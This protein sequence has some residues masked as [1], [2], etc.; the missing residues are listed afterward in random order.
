MWWTNIVGG[1]VLLIVATY[2]IQ[3]LVPSSR[4]KG[5]R[6][7][8]YLR[9]DI[10]P[11]I[12]FFG[13]LLLGLSFAEA[14]R[15]GVIASWGWGI[16]LGLL[17]SAGVWWLLSFRQNRAARRQVS[18]WQILRRYGTPVIAAAI[19]MYLAV[20]VFGAALEVS[21]AAALGLLV[22]AA[23][24]ALFVGSKPISEENHGK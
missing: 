22:I 4:S 24:V 20:R 3:W 13:V 18:V 14:A 19:G 10:A 21:V 2:V 17:I 5:T 16:L 11:I 1:L 23:A 6:R 9:W 8:Q 15:L 12:G 7:R